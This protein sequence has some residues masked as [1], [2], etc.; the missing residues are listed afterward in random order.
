MINKISNRKS[1]EIKAEGWTV[2]KTEEEEK[3]HAD[4]EEEAEEIIETFWKLIV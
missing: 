4:E 1:F 3:K 2:W